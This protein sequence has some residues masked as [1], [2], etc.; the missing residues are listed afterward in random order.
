[1]ELIGLRAASLDD[2]SWDRSTMDIYMA[3]GQPWGYMS[4]DLLKFPKM[5]PMS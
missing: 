4:S 1:M 3:S 2:L 5:P